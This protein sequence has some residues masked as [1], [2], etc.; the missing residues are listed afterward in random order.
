MKLLKYSILVTFFLLISCNQKN[1]NEFTY[2][3]FKDALYYNESSGSFSDLGN[4]E[5]CINRWGEPKYVKSIGTMNDFYG[6]NSK[7]HTIVF[8]WSNIE[9]DNK[10]VEI[11]FEMDDSGKTIKDVFNGTINFLNAKH[12]IVKEFRLTN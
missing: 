6:T 11:Y 3:E 1:E 7:L 12:A 8:K 9:V 2:S 4:L 10:H 5:M